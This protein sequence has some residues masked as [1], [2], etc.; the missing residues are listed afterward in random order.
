MVEIKNQ[1]E[2]NKEYPK[3]KKEIKM[4]DEEFEEQQLVIEDYQ[5]L[6]KLCLRDNEGIEKI[7]LRNLK[8]LQECEIWKCRIKELVI[9]NC[10][11]VKILDVEN[12]LLTNLGFIKDLK[13]LEELKINGNTEL[14]KILE[15]Y[16]NENGLDW[17]TYQKVIQG[18]SESVQELL[19]ELSRKVRDLQEENEK[20]KESLP[21]AID[22]PADF[23]KKYQNLKETLNFFL[24]KERIKTEEIIQLEE[25]S[26]EINLVNEKKDDIATSDLFKR[27]KEDKKNLSTLKRTNKELKE[28]LNSFKKLYFI[29]KQEI[30]Q[31]E[32]EIKKLKVSF[33]ERAKGYKK[34]E[35]KLDELLEVQTEIIIIGR[36]EGYI[37][38]KKDEISG[39]LTLKAQL[40]VEELT[41]LCQLQTEITQLKLEIQSNLNRI[42][43]IFHIKNIQGFNIEG[44]NNQIGDISIKENQMQLIASQQKSNL[45]G[46]NLDDKNKLEGEVSVKN[47]EL[48]PTTEAEN[49]T[50]IGFTAKNGNQISGKVEIENNKIIQEQQL[51]AQIEQFSLNKNT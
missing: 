27:I 35:E 10:P 14:T 13:N 44:S 47:N 41:N 30:E 17:K 49:S 11:Q 21:V 50:T 40:T 28:K 38:K 3:E 2:F 20:L 15:P 4:E 19:K 5:E 37:S 32:K 29:K 16:Y 42:N 31:K 24:K 36:K 8:K 7:I 23:E 46:F 18:S 1:N 39:K 43:Q 12:N 6:E 45:V 26:K 22:N 51:Q 9:E 25:K 33:L 34:T 48:T